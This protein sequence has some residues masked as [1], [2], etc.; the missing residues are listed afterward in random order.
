M[1]NKA[2]KKL[3]NSI[4]YHSYFPRKIGQTGQQIAA[5]WENTRTDTWQLIAGNA[6]LKNKRAK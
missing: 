4:I 1:K 2:S 3:F 5:N 6:A